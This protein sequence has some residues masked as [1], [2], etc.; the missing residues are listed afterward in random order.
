MKSNLSEEGVMSEVNEESK[1]LEITGTQLDLKSRITSK[2]AEMIRRTQEI[3]FHYA[4][5]FESSV[6]PGS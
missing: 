2:T 3:N 6:A 4:N 1:R 5:K